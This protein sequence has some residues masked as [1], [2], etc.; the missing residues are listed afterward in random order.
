MRTA[1]ERVALL[2]VK[3]L[4]NE[5]PLVIQP[6]HDEAFNVEAVTEQFFRDY[7]QAFAHVEAAIKGVLMGEPRRLFTQSLLNRLVFCAF[8]QKKGWL[9]RDPHYL[10]RLWEV[11]RDNNPRGRIATRHN[12]YDDYLY[13]LFFRAL[14]TPT[15]QRPMDAE[16]LALSESLGDV[17]FLNGGLFEPHPQY[18]RPRAVTIPNDA[19]APVLDLFERY[20]FT[21]TESTPFDIEV[22][23]DPEMLGK[24]FEELVTGRHETGSYYTPRPVVSFMCRE[25]LKRYIA[26]ASSLPYDAIARFVDDDDPSRLSDPEAVLDALRRVQVCDPACAVARICW[27]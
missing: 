7:R 21:I 27:A 11:A 25:A 10:R 20:N 8:L 12:F 14:N 4:S 18:D 15:A 3:R 26:Q 5:S 1:S 23:V 2:D 13:A 24:V 19:F 22:A 16:W 9:N 17:P 6:R